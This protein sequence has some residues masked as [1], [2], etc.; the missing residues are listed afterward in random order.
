MIPEWAGD[1]SVSAL[2]VVCTAAVVLSYIKAKS[3]ERPTCAN[4]LTSYLQDNTKV[5]TELI[6]ILREQQE[7]NRRVAE[8][9]QE[10][11][12]Q[13]ILTNHEVVLLARETLSQIKKIEGGVKRV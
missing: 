5:I 6:T 4:Q 8:K 10:A 2:V 9:Q 7:E 11:L 12:Q 3:N 13:L 1:L